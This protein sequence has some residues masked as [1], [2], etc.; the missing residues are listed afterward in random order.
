VSRNIEQPG[1]KA[2]ALV[3]LRGPDVG[4]Q[5]QLRRHRVVL[6]RGESAD[7]ILHD[8]KISRAHAV[9]DAL[10]MGD[11]TLYRLNDLDS[12]NHVFVNGV[13]TATSFLSDGDKIQLGDA[14]LKFELHDAI[15]SMFHGEIR[16]RIRYDEL[17]GL[18]TYETFRTALAWEL[19]R[20]TSS[21]KGCAVLMMDLDDFKKLN[22]TYGHLAGSAVLRDVGAMI[23]ANVRHFDVAARYGG[24]EFVAYLPDTELGE[25]VT[26]AGRVRALLADHAFAHAGR[27]IRLTISMGVSHYPEDGHELQPLIQSADERLYDAKRAGKNRVVGAQGAAA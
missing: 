26:A 15:D 8:K 10:R 13:Q 3:V 14:L 2:A 27:R 17:T 7:L 25:A 19:G 1:K 9:V 24:E 23:R 12:A 5:Y 22:D 11:Q 16:N 20:E 21:A 6:G 4:R 18:L